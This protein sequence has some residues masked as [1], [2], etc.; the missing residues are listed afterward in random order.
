LPSA[1]GEI[2]RT[3]DTNLN[4]W[5][6]HTTNLTNTSWT[7]NSIPAAASADQSGATPGVNQVQEFR[8]PQGSDQR[9]FLRLK[10]KYQTP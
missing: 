7:S 6:E 8:T 5:S 1:R 3:N 4:V 9:K 10:A 2:I